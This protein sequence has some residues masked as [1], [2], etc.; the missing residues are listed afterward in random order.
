MEQIISHPR[1][2]RRSAEEI[3]HLLTEFEKANVSVKE[4][5]ATHN[6]S[7][8][9]FHKWQ[10]RY[11]SKEPIA[12]FVPLQIASLIAPAVLFAEVKGIKIYQPVTAAYLKELFA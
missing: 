2:V 3:I 8:A 4:F 11:K 7:R 10:S 12:G 5:C 6:I 1:R 9:S